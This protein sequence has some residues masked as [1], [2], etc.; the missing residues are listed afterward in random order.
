MLSTVVCADECR[1]THHESRGAGSG[2][3]AEQAVGNTHRGIR[4][5]SCRRLKPR[6][7]GPKMD[8]LPQ[9]PHSS[10]RRLHTV[11][12][13]HH[14]TSSGGN[15]GVFLFSNHESSTSL[16]SAE[17]RFSARFSDTDSQIGPEGV[18]SRRL[19]P[20]PLKARRVRAWYLPKLLC[21]GDSNKIVPP[22]IR[23]HH[24]IASAVTV[25]HAL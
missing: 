16:L 10:T 6:K 12:T 14:S 13:I 7:R 19:A 24:H 18:R 20:L 2:Q 4:L 25:M 17:T 5:S 9:T 3:H 1:T 11:K 15:F 21:D 23:P 22:S 8:A